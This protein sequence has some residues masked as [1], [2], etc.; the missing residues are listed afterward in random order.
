ML[1]HR[2][3]TQSFR[4]TRRRLL[5]VFLV[6]LLCLA[7]EATVRAD[8]GDVEAGT[9]ADCHPAEAITWQE[10]PHACEQ[11]GPTCEACHG[12]YI[13]NHPQSGTMQL[14]VGAS[15]CQDCHA[16]TYGAWHDTAHAGANVQCTSC[17]LPHSQGNRLAGEELCGSCHRDVTVNWAHQNA[18]VHCADCHFSLSPDLETVGAHAN[19]NVSQAYSACAECHERGIH[20]LSVNTAARQIDF[21]QFTTLTQRAKDAAYE[22]EEVKRTNRSLQAM[23]VVSLGFGL[24][25]GGVLGAIFVLVVGYVAQRRE[26]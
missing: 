12:S 18:D 24:G 3:A 22:L 8:A 16:D 21:S 7:L 6:G 2:I 14:P 5:T 1:M 13:P 15:C 17:H 23:S 25:V 9:C 11:A 10:S 26:K 20:D 19:H 4:A